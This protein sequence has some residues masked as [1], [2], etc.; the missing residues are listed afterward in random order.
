MV[1]IFHSEAI[2]GSPG[3]IRVHFMQSREVVVV[4]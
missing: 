3:G 4:D 1:Y 2:V